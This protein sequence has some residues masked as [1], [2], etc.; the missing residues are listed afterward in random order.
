MCCIGGGSE[1][2]WPVLILCG[3]SLWVKKGHLNWGLKQEILLKTSITKK[4]LSVADEY[5]KFDT[6]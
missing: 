1:I 4:F 5:W 6:L 2:T 3:I